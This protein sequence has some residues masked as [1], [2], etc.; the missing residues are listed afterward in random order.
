MGTLEILK[1]GLFSS[2]QDNGRQQY[3]NWGLPMGGAM[4]KISAA[5]ANLLLDNPVHAP[6]LEITGMGPQLRTSHD[7]Q[8]SCTG[9]LIKIKINQ[10]PLKFSNIINLQPGDLI[11]FGTIRK[12]YRTYLGIKHGFISEQYLGSV[13]RV[14]GW[15]DSLRL[16]GGEKLAFHP[17][18]QKIKNNAGIKSSVDFDNKKIACFK[19]PEWEMLSEFQQEYLLNSAFAISPAATRMAFPLSQVSEV[20]QHDQSILTSP[21]VPG[22]VQLTPAG[23]LIVL[24][25]DAQT[26]GGYPRVL[27]LSQQAI[28]R[29]SQIRIGA[30]FKFEPL[31]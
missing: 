9:G 21:V 23:Q 30:T 14:A 25:R 28:N 20:L 3:R 8:L 13:S 2:L 12:G 6:V 16:A 17:Y 1:S 27:I 10:Q 7:C 18:A 22:V 5:Q 26:T 19:G 29:I 4:D 24:M 15:Q 11:Q 31:I